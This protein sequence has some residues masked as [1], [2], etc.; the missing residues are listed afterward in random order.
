MWVSPF[1]RVPVALVGWLQRETKRKHPFCFL[2][3]GGTQ[4]RHKHAH[5]P[6]GPKSFLRIHQDQPCDQ[7][8]TWRCVFEAP[9]QDV[10]RNF[11]GKPPTTF[12]A[13]PSGRGAVLTL[14]TKRSF[15]AG[16][17]W[18][19]P[20]PTAAQR[21]A[22]WLSLAHGSGSKNRYQNGTLARGN[23]DQNLRNPPCLILSHTHILPHLGDAQRNS[24]P[25]KGFRLRLGGLPGRRPHPAGLLE[26]RH[27]APPPPAAR[28]TNRRQ[29]C[30]KGRPRTLGK[31][32][33]QRKPQLG[34]PVERLESGYPS[35]F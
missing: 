25:H 8:S 35:L 16:W 9:L 3:V 10:L 29:Q 22:Q 24:T 5:V 28:A 33:A 26:G 23:M 27:S 31:R 13:S 20:S 32:N 4:S 1:L 18:S 6:K 2:G 7:G 11:Q 34:P 17:T 14:K 15:P 30:C 21:E 12:D 19:K